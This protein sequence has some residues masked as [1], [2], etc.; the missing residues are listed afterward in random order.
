MPLQCNSTQQ[1]LYSVT[2]PR[3]L[4]HTV[5]PLLYYGGMDCTHESVALDSGNS[6]DSGGSGGSGLNTDVYNS[7]SILMT[8]AGRS[9]E[10]ADYVTVVQCCTFTTARFPVHT[11]PDNTLFNGAYNIHG[12]WTKTGRMMLSF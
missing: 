4:Q 2:V 6:G 9:V 10:Y 1:C 12:S 11:S 3:V 5:A 8:V 7:C